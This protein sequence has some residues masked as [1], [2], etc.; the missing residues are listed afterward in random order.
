MLLEM[1]IYKT[2]KI[3]VIISRSYFIEKKYLSFLTIFSL[4][5]YCTPLKKGNKVSPRLTEVIGNLI[6]PEVFFILIKNK[7]NKQTKNLT[8]ILRKLF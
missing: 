3:T 6:F 2:G 7:T 1:G 5:A 4:K 8:R